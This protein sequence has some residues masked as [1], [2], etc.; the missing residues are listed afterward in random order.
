MD[1]NPKQ[2]ATQILRALIK[3]P[4]ILEHHKL[5]HV[6]MDRKDKDEFVDLAT[7]LS[8]EEADK[9]KLIA[10]S[11]G[12]N[13]Q[14]LATNAIAI[15]LRIDLVST[16]G[17]QYEALAVEPRGFAH[18]ISRE[19]FAKE[20]GLSPITPDSGDINQLHA[21]AAEMRQK[22]LDTLRNKPSSVVV[23]KRPD[24]DSHER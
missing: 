16:P 14:D 24:P 12:M 20:M 7:A 18:R 2:Q 10:K 11:H 15:T 17:V 23:I 5:Y 1:G 13:L 4:E 6:I 3:H 22:K 8:K 21:E 19:E 9:I